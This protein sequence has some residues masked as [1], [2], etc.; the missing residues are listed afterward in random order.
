MTRI[1][2]GK[3]LTHKIRN[4]SG[5]YLLNKRTFKYIGL[6]LTILGSSGWLYFTLRPDRIDLNPYEALG[7][8]AGDETAALLSNSGRL[9]LVDADF[10]IYKLL[11]PTTEAEIKSFKK[12]IRKTNLKIAAIERVPIARPS[13]ARTGI[14]MQPGQIS[15]LIARHPEA[16]AIVLFVGL[17]GLDDL[18]GSGSD[19]SKPKLVLVSNYESYYKEL[20]Q[21][22]AIQMAIV[23]V[24]TPDADEDRTIHSRKEWFERHYLVVTPERIAE[25]GH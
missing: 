23:P 24:G 7:E 4:G 6:V 16:D 19:N 15:S 18:K 11:A 1:A 20:L 12:A 21:M 22:R 5:I 9:V 8:T 10:G 13:M 17:A 14:F 2:P 3:F 25:L